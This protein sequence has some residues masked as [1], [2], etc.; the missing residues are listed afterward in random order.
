MT[1]KKL[2]IA[3]TLILAAT[4]GVAHAQSIRPTYSYPSSAASKEGAASVQVGESPV[5]FTPFVG[6]GVGHDSNVLLSNTNERGSNLYI[7]SPGF[8]IDTRTAATVFQLSHQSQFGRYTSSSD[9]NYLDHVSKAQLDMAFSGR[10][11]LRLGF[12]YIRGHDPRGSTDRGISTS[13]DKYSLRSPNVTYAYGAPGAQG[14]VELYAADTHK[15]YINNRDRTSFSDRDT[16][17]YGGAFYWRVMPKTYVL[18]EARETNISYEASSSPFSGDEHRVFAGVMWEATAATT[19]TFK[20][21]QL[22]RSFDRGGFPSKT[23]TSWEGL[24]T[25]SPRTYSQFDF[26]TARSTNE[27]T[28]LGSFILTDVY[29]VNWTHSWTSVVSTGVN[30]RYQRDEYQGF[31]RTDDTKSLG[32]RAGYKFRRWLTLGAEY[33]YTNRASNQPGI[34][35][36]KNLYLL[37]ATASM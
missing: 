7:V 1:K 37:T 25:W 13:P 31:N 22:R 19:G 15:T 11:F 30:L 23:S 24:I 16:T 35:Y 6:L 8:K 5:Y 18:A 29:G 27:S 9:D 14:R 28:G 36:D 12:D 3:L 2:K 33:T 4:A 10:S 17:E 34:D 32:L 20:V 26:Y 21:G